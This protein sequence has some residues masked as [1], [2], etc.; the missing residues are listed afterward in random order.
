MRRISVRAHL[1]VRRV[2]EHVALKT[3][4]S[5]EAKSS[6]FEAPG[7]AVEIVD[8]EFDLGLDGHDEQ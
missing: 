1:P 7:E 4:R 5:F 8:A 3:A 2:V 6:G